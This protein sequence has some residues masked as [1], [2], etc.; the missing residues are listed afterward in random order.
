[1]GIAMIGSVSQYAKSMKMTMDWKQKKASGDYTKKAD[2][3]VS[4]W[5]RYR[6]QMEDIRKAAAEDKSS[7]YM[8]LNSGKKLTAEEMDYLREHDPEAYKTAKEIEAEQK[9]YEEQLKR[10]RTKEEAERLRMT[11]LSHK[12]AMA[13]AVANNPNIPKGQKM[14]ILLK[15]N[16]KMKAVREAD[17][18][19]KRSSQYAALPTEEEKAQEAEEKME[20]L[21]GEPWQEKAAEET[22]ESVGESSSESTEESTPDNTLER[23]GAEKEKS[24]QKVHWVD[25]R[26]AVEVPKPNVEQ[27]S[28]KYS[29]EAE[30]DNPWEKRTV[31]N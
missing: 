7:I 12:A 26:Q 29:Q 5:D 1:M 24:P 9:Q 4:E 8:K 28:R 3:K 10:C 2:E 17:E 6:Q 16:A 27:I 30:F 13:K 18:E 15:E 25:V 23:E 31:R 14:A 21:R 22:A 11:Y 19:F 20:E